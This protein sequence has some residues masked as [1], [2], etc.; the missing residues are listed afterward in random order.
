[1][2]LKGKAVKQAQEQQFQPQAV[3]DQLLMVQLYEF[4]FA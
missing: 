4:I 3:W 1:M 2:F